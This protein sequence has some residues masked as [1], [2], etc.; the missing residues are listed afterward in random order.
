MFA[1]NSTFLTF[2]GII[3][4]LEAIYN[5]ISALFSDLGDAFR[6]SIIIII[7]LTAI[8]FAY[9]FAKKAIHR[10]QEKREFNKKTKK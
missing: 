8:V 7:A 2:F 5:L 9:V 1:D 10:F 4:G 3:V 6:Y